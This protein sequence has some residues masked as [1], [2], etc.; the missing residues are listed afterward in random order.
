MRFYEGEPTGASDDAP[1]QVLVGIAEF[2]VATG[3][4]VLSSSG[5]GSCVAVAVYDPVVSVAGLLHAMLPERTEPDAD[6]AKYV[7]AGVERTVEA[8]LAEGGESSRL[9]AKVAGGSD[10]LNFESDGPGIGSRNVAQSREALAALD[11]PIAA[12]DVGGDYGRSVELSAATGEL[13]VTGPNRDT[14]TL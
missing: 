6:A 9:R 2:G 4:A 1:E 7:D 12:T 13:T 3:D 11:V 8:V 14:T 5:L 10:M